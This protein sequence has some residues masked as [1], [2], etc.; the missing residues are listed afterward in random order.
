LPGSSRIVGL[1]SR[2]SFAGSVS[3][4]PVAR[5]YSSPQYLIATFKRL[6]NVFPVTFN[7]AIRLDVYVMNLVKRH[8][9]SGN[10]TL[11]QF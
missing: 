6:R 4:K 9:G 7:P 2:I 8:S 5:H 10:T 11:E 3:T 1:A